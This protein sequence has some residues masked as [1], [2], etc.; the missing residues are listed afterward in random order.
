M[1]VSRILGGALIV[2]ALMITTVPTTVAADAGL[3]AT[4]AAWQ[5]AFNAG[6]F[7]TVAEHYASDAC[8]MPP[9]QETVY[10]TEGVLGALVGAQ[11]LGIASVELAVTEDTTSEKMGWGAGTYKTF[12]EDGSEL[13]SGKWMNVS[14][15][16]DGEW[17]IH[18]DIWNS[19]LPLE[20]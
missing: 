20:E 8:R 6:D 15:M 13:D 5:E 11:E 3:A 9:N 18:C 7:E 14:K 12:A 4:I 17:K 16:V 2:L 10:G 1:N 19:N